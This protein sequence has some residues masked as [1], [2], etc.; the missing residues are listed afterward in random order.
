MGTLQ[1]RISGTE[2]SKGK[3][4]Y[5]L[6]DLKL[7]VSYYNLFLPILCYFI[8]D[9]RIDDHVLDPVDIIPKRNEV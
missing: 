8:A 5:G 3:M 6:T 7:R 2:E 1:K 4:V 9:K